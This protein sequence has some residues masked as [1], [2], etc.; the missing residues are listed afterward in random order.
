MVCSLWRTFAQRDNRLWYAT[1]M[2][3]PSQHRTYCEKRVGALPTTP[4]DISLFNISLYFLWFLSVIACESSDIFLVF[5]GF[6]NGKLIYYISNIKIYHQY[7]TYYYSNEYKNFV[8]LF[9]FSRFKL[10]NIN[11][12]I[13]KA[14]NKVEIREI[15][16][17]AMMEMYALRFRR[18][19]GLVAD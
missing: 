11:V 12:I 10:Y 18:S 9:G 19:N 7:N 14:I 3:Y 1:F 13:N 2:K 8:I 15:L 17:N 16:Y 4:Q 6:A 5:F